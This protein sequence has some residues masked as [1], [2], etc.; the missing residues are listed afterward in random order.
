MV[1]HFSK[2]NKIKYSFIFLVGD[3]TMVVNDRSDLNIA[4]ELNRI[5]RKYSL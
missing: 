5:L 1:R 2:S 4:A 3:G